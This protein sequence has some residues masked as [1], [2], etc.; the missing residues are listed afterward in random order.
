[1]S[2]TFGSV[3]FRV[4]K[5]DLRGRLSRGELLP[6]L[7]DIGFPSQPAHEWG[8]QR[9]ECPNEERASAEARSLSK[10]T[11]K[12]DQNFLRRP[13]A[14]MLVPPPR[15]KLPADKALFATL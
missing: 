5:K 7:K 14:S 1:M 2:G 9:R 13:T 3:K 15:V 4:K 11:V 12:S 8:N 10:M 6:P